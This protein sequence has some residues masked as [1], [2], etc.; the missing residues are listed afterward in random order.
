MDDESGFTTFG[1]TRATSSSGRAIESPAVW[2]LGRGVERAE[3]GVESLLTAPVGLMV[4]L[5][6][7]GPDQLVEVVVGGSEDGAV[8]VGADPEYHSLAVGV[9]KPQLAQRRG[10][11]IAR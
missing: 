1:C 8:V 7:H 11:L 2:C 6:C 4:C 9:E 3:C 10:H 5:G